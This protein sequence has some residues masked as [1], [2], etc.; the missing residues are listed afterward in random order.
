MLKNRR[1]G[2]VKK[3]FLESLGGVWVGAALILYLFGMYKIASDDN[4]YTTKDVAIALFIFP[5]PWWVGGSELY[6]IASTSEEER[7]IEEECLAV[8]ETI[9]VP[10]KSRLRF[11]ECY[12]ETKNEYKC[13]EKLF[14]NNGS[15]PLA[16]APPA[17]TPEHGANPSHMFDE[18]EKPA[19]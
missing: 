9:G 18:F 2:S 13:K 7:K 17:E 16:E 5:Y 3:T 6:K 19:R 8:T 10:R 1:G 15:R 11:C 4:R 12:S 14:S